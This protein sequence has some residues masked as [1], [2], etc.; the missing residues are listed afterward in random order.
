VK[1]RRPATAILLV[2]LALLALTACESAPTTRVL[3][4]GNSF[5]Y[6]NGGIGQQLH[7]LD[8]SIGAKERTAG[9]Y[10]LDDHWTGLDAVLAIREGKYN[11]VVLQEQSQTSVFATDMFFR[12]VRRF[13]EEIRKSG[14]QTLLL[15]TWERPDSAGQ[16]ITTANISAAYRAIADEV[17]ARLAPA[18]EAFARAL[19]ERPDLALNSTD[20]HPTMEGTYLAACVL[21]GA[22]TSESPVGRPYSTAGVSR[23]MAA[24]LQ[25][26]A[27]ESLGY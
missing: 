15:M 3:L 19:A 4:I 24:F 13:D 5:T 1:S 23:E 2:C 18:G 27:A 22:I 16:G 8:A 10:T 9:G 14:A 11:Y 26:I 12:D 7:G 6:Y 17:G 20:G 21:Y 25:R